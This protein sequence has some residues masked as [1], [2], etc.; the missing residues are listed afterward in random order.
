MSE[1]LL[2]HFRKMKSGMWNSSISLDGQIMGYQCMAQHSSILG[3]KLKLKY[4][5]EIHHVLFTAG[6]Y[7]IASLNISAKNNHNLCALE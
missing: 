2:N 7:V 4:K 6:N 5:L 1:N 3:E